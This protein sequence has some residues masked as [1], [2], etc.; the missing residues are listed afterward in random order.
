[1]VFAQF[2]ASFQELEAFGENTAFLYPSLDSA[3][4]AAEK[5]QDSQAGC[6]IW[7]EGQEEGAS[8]FAVKASGVKA[9]NWHYL[10][11]AFPDSLQRID[12]GLLKWAVYISIGMFFL[13][14]SLLFFRRYKICGA[15]ARER[16][17]SK[18]PVFFMACLWVFYVKSF[19]L[20]E[21]EGFPV[22]LLPGKWSDME[23]WQA[24]WEGFRGQMQAVIS[25]QDSPAIRPYYSGAVQSLLWLGSS[26]FIFSQFFRIS[27]KAKDPLPAHGV[28]ALLA[29]LPYIRFAGRD[30]R[31]LLY[32]FPCF[33][34]CFHWQAAVSG[35]RA[36]R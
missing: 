4:P 6:R 2:S 32:F 22:W 31:M 30:L 18:R 23:G 19:V 27:S 14:V 26:F 20:Q 12:V 28:L 25:Y 29:F 16:R 17:P 7:M 36:K 13:G 5:A 3:K 21:A 34:A 11:Y 9:I 1:M 33:I 24:L 15:S 8:V 35:R 10:E